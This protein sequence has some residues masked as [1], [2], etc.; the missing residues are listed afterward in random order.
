MHWI[1]SCPHCQATLNPADTIILLAR[2]EDRQLMMGLHPQPG[3]YQVY[4]PTGEEIAP[5]SRWMFS[6]P[7][8]REALVTEVSDDLCALDLHTEGDTHRIFF[9]RVAGEQATF[10][11][12]AEGMLKDYGIHTDRYLEHLIHLKYMK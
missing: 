1:Y 5:G 3:N 4:L 11:V 10:M 2:C 9:S 6:C 7:V 8:C 12:T